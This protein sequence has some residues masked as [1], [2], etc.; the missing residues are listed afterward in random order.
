MG[1]ARPTAL[2]KPCNLQDPGKRDLNLISTSLVSPSLLAG[3]LPRKIS[4]LGDP[5][6]EV[7]AWTITMAAR[8]PIGS[9]WADKW[10]SW[11]EL[12]MDNILPE[13]GRFPVVL[14]QKVIV[15]HRKF[16]GMT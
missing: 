6:V 1:K 7:D 15:Q 11:L 4:L 5:N 13:L 16:I 12:D 14:C 10:L 2:I 3:P 9:F 8:S